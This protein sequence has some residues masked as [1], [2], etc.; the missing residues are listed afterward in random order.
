MAVTRLETVR[1]RARIAVADMAPEALAELDRTL[2]L[3]F[4]EHAAYQNAQARAFATGRITA[5]VATFLY[6]ALGEIGSAGNGGWA[7]E[8]STADKAVATQAIGIILDAE[9]ALAR[10]AGSR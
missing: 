6:A 3:D 2:A 4:S 1:E 7:A 9:I 8:T 5:D 10:A